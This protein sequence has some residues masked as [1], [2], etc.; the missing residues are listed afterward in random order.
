MLHMQNMVIEVQS[1]G[2]YGVA[3][4]Q[5]DNGKV[6]HIVNYNYNEET[7]KLTPCQK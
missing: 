5:K 1:D 7:H 4:H 6:L 3:V 2:K